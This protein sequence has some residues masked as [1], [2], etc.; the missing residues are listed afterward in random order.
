MGRR[1]RCTVVLNY[2][3]YYSLSKLSGLLFDVHPGELLLQKGNVEKLYSGRIVLVVVKNCSQQCFWTSWFLQ[4]CV[5]LYVLDVLEIKRVG[6]WALPFTDYFSAYPGTSLYAHLIASLKRRP[7][8]NLDLNNT[9]EKH[10]V[11]LYLRNLVLV[12]KV[13]ISN[14]WFYFRLCTPTFFCV[15]YNDCKNLSMFYTQLNKKGI[16]HIQALAG[17]RDLLSS[18]ALGLTQNDLSFHIQQHDIPNQG[19]LGHYSSHA[20]TF[21]CPQDH[22]G[23]LANLF[24]NHRALQSMLAFYHL[25]CEESKIYLHLKNL[26]AIHWLG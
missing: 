20:W 1:S 25:H 19:A 8:Y 16:P 21:P 24:G 9:M 26:H 6:I 23:K 12:E 5:D 11:E 3:K 13:P 10:P 15:G 22:P 2:K 14:S 18:A 4:R 7:C 17:L